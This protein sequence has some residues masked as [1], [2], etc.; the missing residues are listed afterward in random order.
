G[1]VTW[2]E[3][4]DFFG[5]GPNDQVYVLDRA[6]G[7]VRFGDGNHGRIPVANLDR[8]QTNIVARRY[9]FGGGARSNVEAGAISTLMTSIAGIDAGKVG[10]PFAA[11]GGTDEETLAA[12]KLRAPQAL[13]SHDR[14]V[15]AADYEMLAREAGPVARAK[16][17]PLVNPN[18]PGSE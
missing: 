12:A 8:A 7:Q 9:Q 2:T 10:N 3:S 15:T 14:A 16:A 4:E 6:A 11:D 17:L 18:F 5:A 13:K 1:F